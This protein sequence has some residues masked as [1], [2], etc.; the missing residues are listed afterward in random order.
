MYEGI[1]RDT[2]STKENPEY[3]ELIASPTHITHKSDLLCI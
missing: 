3:D 2:E 1:E